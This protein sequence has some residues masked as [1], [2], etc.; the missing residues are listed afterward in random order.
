MNSR[1]RRPGRPPDV[2]VAVDGD[3]VEYA[4]QIGVVNGVMT[5]LVLRYTPAGDLYA[6][7]ERVSE[8]ERSAECSGPGQSA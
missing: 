5:R 8:T 1:D 3:S 6:S 7:I 4:I 2:R